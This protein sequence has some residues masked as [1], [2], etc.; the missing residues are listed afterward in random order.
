MPLDVRF[1]GT[2]RIRLI[3]SPPGLVVW[4]F[5]TTVS[6]SIATILKRA[7]ENPSQQQ[8]SCMFVIPVEHVALQVTDTAS[9][10][11]LN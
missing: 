2:V 10:V 9:I 6:R 4:L 5:V 11:V 8:S 7:L 1:V 3:T